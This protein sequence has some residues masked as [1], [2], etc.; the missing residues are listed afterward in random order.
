MNQESKYQEGETT[1]YNGMIYG[2][3]P[4]GITPLPAVTDEY[5]RLI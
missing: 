3:G 4:A 1:S 5:P 2:K